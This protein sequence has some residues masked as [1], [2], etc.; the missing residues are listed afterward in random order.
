MKMISRIFNGLAIW[1]IIRIYGINKLKMINK[2]IWNSQ[3]FNRW[4]V[5]IILE[6]VIFIVKYV[7]NIIHVGCAMMLKLANIH[8]HDTKPQKYAANTAVRNSH[9]EV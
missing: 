8:S 1:K 2:C 6:V 9:S 7:K 4:V 3:R 5:N